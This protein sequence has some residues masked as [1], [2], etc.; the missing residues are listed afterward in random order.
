MPVYGPFASATGARST[1]VTVIAVEAIAMPPFPSLARN[2]TLYV[3]AWVKLGVQ[4]NVPEV[5][6]AFAVNVAP[7]G[8]PRAVSVM[9]SPS[10]SEAVTMKVMRLPSA[11]DAVAGAVT[12]GFWLALPTVMTV[13]AEPER[14]FDAVKVTL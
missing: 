4:L 7:V 2:V 6:P 5:P 3:P 9:V 13:V 1:S 14:A 11:P 12:V 10:G 8:S